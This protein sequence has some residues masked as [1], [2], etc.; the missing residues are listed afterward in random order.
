MSRFKLIQ[1]VSRETTSASFLV[2][3]LVAGELP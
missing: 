1:G 3:F 2:S